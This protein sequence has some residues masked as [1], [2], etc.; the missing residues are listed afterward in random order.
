[1]PHCID[2]HRIL[3]CA[4]LALAFGS[5]AAAGP[6]SNF[7]EELTST[8]V[9]AR[10]QAGTTTILVPIG[11]TEQN[12]AHIALG[13]HNARARALAARVAAA[14]GN[15]L[16]AP[17]IAYV[18]EGAV[19]PPTGHMRHAGTIS[20]PEAAFEQVLDGAARSFRVHGFHDIVFLGDHGGY[21]K[22]EQAVAARLNREWSRS[23]VRV[24]AL[25]EYYHAASRGVDE[26]LHGR[27]YSS[28]EIGT[29]AGLADTALTMALV[30]SM[31]RTDRLATA[32]ATPGVRGDP[33][34]ASAA[35]GE[36]G[37]QLI[38]TRTIAAIRAATRR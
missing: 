31:V 37:A 4:C 21:Q 24:Q 11:G 8:E 2:V 35:L 19:N 7:L 30:P 10:V 14:L 6:P 27:G 25:P 9:A 29:H 26:L 34:R 13:K 17:V 36:A 23:D 15:A 1:M 38:V 5:C 16:V 18:P 12:G 32:A 28:D 22:G 3:A 33:R 20:V